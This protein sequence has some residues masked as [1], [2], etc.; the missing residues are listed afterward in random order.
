MAEPTVGAAHAEPISDP[1]RRRV[2]WTTG[3]AHALH[4]GYTDLLYVLLPVWQAEFGLGYAALGLLRG[5]YTG[6]M[7]ALQ[8]PSAWLAERY[9]T[10][11]IL[12]VGTALAGGAYLLIGVTGAG[13]VALTV[14]LVLGGAGSA[15][16]HPLASALVA[17]AFDQGRGR[18]ALGTYNFAGDVGKMVIP[19]AMAWLIVLM[20][21]REALG[22]VGCLGLL[23]AV[24]IPLALP[25]GANRPT[26]PASAKP[27][28]QRRQGS[29]PAY[30]FPMLLSIGVIDSATRMG[31]L[32][33]LPFVLVAKGAG[34]E[35][36]GLA[37]SLVFAGGAAGKL[38]CGWLGEKLGVL[39]AVLL[40]EAMTAAGILALIPMPLLP[41]LAI[42]PL[43]GLALN[44]TSSVLYGTVPELVPAERRERAFGVFYTGTV[45]GGAVAPAIYGLIGDFTGPSVAIAVIAA[46][47]LVT[48]PLAILLDPALRPAEVD[49]GTAKS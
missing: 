48:V 21:W 12:A 10:V 17:R 35:T 20:P 34:L 5:L 14:A 26:P 38:I 32:A 30:A 16:Q 19:A 27:A 37:L 22:L 45:G 18:V 28:D 11:T 42:L 36:I 8:V 9:G 49:P 2:L 33:F 41:S 15:T 6:V 44:G 43:I 13:F 46:L 3:G 25:R 39:R 23:T 4:D 31:F 40:T 7:A 47:C 29:A 24:A 1:A